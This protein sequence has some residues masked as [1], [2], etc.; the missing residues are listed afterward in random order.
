MKCLIT[1]FLKIFDIK[2]NVLEHWPKRLSLLSRNLQSTCSEEIFIPENLKKDQK[3]K[4]F[5]SMVKE[6]FHWCEHICALRAQKNT[7]NN[8]F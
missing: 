4:F 2:T 5:S 7:L 3:T 8:F 6:A 1:Y